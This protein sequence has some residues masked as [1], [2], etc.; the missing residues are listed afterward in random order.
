MFVAPAAVC[1]FGKV[2]QENSQNEDELPF[3]LSMVQI[4]EN[5]RLVVVCLRGTA[6]LP[7]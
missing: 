5:I 7:A 6:L 1:H 4:V 3:L 2:L